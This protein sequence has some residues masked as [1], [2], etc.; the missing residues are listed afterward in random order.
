MSISI[1][2]TSISQIKKIGGKT[3]SSET[4]YSINV[5]TKDLRVVCFN[6]PRV[7]HS[8]RDFL[9]VLK[10]IASPLPKDVFAYCVKHNFNSTGHN[11]WSL[12]NAEEDFKRI[13]LP[14]KHW[15]ISNVNS[16]YQISS[17]YPETVIIFYYF[18]Y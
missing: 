12:Y 4:S 14:D 16:K 11:G 13:G 6:F 10:R 15:R 17:S 8:R 2:L 5:F 1:P 3:G 7:K 9:L 18:Y